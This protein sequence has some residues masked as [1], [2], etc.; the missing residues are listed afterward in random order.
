MAQERAG[1]MDMNRIFQKEEPVMETEQEQ[2]QEWEGHRRGW[3]RRAW[4]PRASQGEGGEQP[5]QR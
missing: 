5:G 2:P 4:N 3:R 1:Y